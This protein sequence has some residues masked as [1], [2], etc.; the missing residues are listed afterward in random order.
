MDEKLY[1]ACAKSIG[2][3]VARIATQ[4]RMKEYSIAANATAGMRK[5][6]RNGRHMCLQYPF[7][8]NSDVVPK[9]AMRWM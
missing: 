7:M 9:T 1:G 8:L 4:Q 6:S 2:C 3:V 5:K